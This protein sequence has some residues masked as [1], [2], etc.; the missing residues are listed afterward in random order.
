MRFTC[1]APVAVVALLLVRSA[2]AGPIE[3]VSYSEEAD[4][5]DES[6]IIP[7]T[8]SNAT[9]FTDLAM[10]N[11]PPNAPPDFWVD[12]RQQAQRPP[13]GPGRHYEFMYCDRRFDKKQ[14]ICGGSC[15]YVQGN[16]QA[17]ELTLFTP[18]TSCIVGLCDQPYQICDMKNHLMEDKMKCHGVKHE[19]GPLANGMCLAQG[20]AAAIRVGA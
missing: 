8:L 1:S 2:T 17:G 14:H 19:G 10:M 9:A 7:E 16:V 15:N 11:V 4:S 5:A 20:S 3:F 18:Q 13:L 6:T 12:K